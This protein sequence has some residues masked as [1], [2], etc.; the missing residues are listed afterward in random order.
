MPYPTASY[1]FG[2]PGQFFRDQRQINAGRFGQN[3]ALGP[4]K[5]RRAPFRD[6]SGPLLQQRLAQQGFYQGL[7]MTQGLNRASLL[8]QLAYRNRGFPGP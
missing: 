1:P 8:T 3:V 7:P 5:G 4:Q 6:L 2:Q